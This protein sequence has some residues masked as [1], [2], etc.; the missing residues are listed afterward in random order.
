MKP[1]TP[2]GLDRIIAAVGREPDNREYLMRN[3]ESDCREYWFD[4]ALRGTNAAP[5]RKLVKRIRRSLEKTA[6]LI[7]SNTLI[8]QATS[9]HS[10]GPLIESLRELED[11]QP[12]KRK[13]RS[14]SA[15]EF[16]AGAL[17]PM[18]HRDNFSDSNG[19]SQVAFA[20]AVLAELG[21]GRKRETI[22]RAMRRFAIDRNVWPS[23]PSLID[24]MMPSTVR[25]ALMG[26][27]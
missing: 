4:I 10:L 17:L 21:L 25:K 1:I 7:E 13:G 3:I 23:S 11:W 20:E 22:V 2:A 15:L 18:T 16:L 8:K 5:T 27:K 19:E 9:E 14:P 24:G 26:R 12:P 6:R